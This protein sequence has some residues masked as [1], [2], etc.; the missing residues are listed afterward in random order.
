VVNIQNRKKKTRINIGARRKRAL[1]II[2]GQR[3]RIFFFY[4][5]NLQEGSDL[6]RHRFGSGKKKSPEC[7]EGDGETGKQIKKKAKGP[8]K[9]STE[10]RSIRFLA[11][12]CGLQSQVSRLVS[13]S[14]ILGIASD[15]F[16]ISLNTPP[17]WSSINHPIHQKQKK[18]LSSRG[19]KRGPS[20]EHRNWELRKKMCTL[21]STRWNRIGSY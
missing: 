13:I 15:A 4:A 16:P 10:D 20:V 11:S 5:M 8:Q 2:R 18:L 17:K 14:T 21:D 7:E 19:D 12:L 1:M 3:H 9:R 6:R